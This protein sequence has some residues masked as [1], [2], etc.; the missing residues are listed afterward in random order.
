MGIDPKTKVVRLN[1]AFELGIFLAVKRLGSQLQK[2]KI[3]LV[4]DKHQYRYRDALSDISGLDIA[5][6]QGSPKNAIRQVRDWL[7]TSR[8]QQADSLPGGNYIIQQF[9]K[10]SRK[11]PGASK[12]EKLDVQEL[13]YPDLCRAIE[14][15]LKKNA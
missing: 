13:T 2:Q 3:A 10:F 12:K 6:H 14:S 4:L 7:D 11:L 9:R 1:M 5:C 8:H 15:W